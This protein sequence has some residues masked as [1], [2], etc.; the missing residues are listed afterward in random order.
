MWTIGSGRVVEADV[1]TRPTFA[2]LLAHSCSTQ[3]LLLHYFWLFFAL[4]LN[5][6]CSYCPIFAISRVYELYHLLHF[7]YSKAK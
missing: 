3:A 5:Y 7:G 6:S 2:L 4:L 1:Q